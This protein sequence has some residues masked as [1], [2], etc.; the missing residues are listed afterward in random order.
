MMRVANFGR[1]Q[2]YTTYLAVS[3]KIEDVEVEQN[4]FV[5]NYGTYPMILGQPYI[6]ASTMKTKV[7]DD[8]SHYAQIQSLNEKKSI[9]FLTVKFE[10]E[11]HQFQLRDGLVSTSSDDF[12]DF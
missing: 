1:T 10:N 5:F 9:Q 11:K 4:F 8:G 6:T 3:A 2:L 7:L 12:V